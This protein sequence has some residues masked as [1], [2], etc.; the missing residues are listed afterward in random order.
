LK[1]TKNLYEYQYSEQ[2]ITKNA[3]VSSILLFHQKPVISIK[4]ILTIA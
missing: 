3:I 4:K 1:L 2:P